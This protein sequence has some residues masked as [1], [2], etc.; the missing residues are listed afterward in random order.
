SLP[1]HLSNK[2]KK[3]TKEE[4]WVSRDIPHFFTQN[5]FYFLLGIESAQRA[6]G[7]T[8]QRLRLHEM[9]KLMYL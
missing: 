6:P 5:C 4:G 8:S 1:I 7:G 9:F 3:T 2:K